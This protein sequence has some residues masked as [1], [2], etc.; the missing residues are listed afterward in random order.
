MSKLQSLQKEIEES[1]RALQGPI[2]DTI[3]RQDDSKRIELMNSTLEKMNNPSI[4]I[5]KL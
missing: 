3:Y 2:D 1:K 4:F 5:C